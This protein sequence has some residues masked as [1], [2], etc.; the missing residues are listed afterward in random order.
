MSTR[1]NII[2]RTV[3]RI[4]IPVQRQ[5]VCDIPQIRILLE[6][7]SLICIIIPRPQILKSGIR[8]IALCIIPIEVCMLCTSQRHLAVWV[9]LVYACHHTVIPGIG[10]HAA[11]SVIQIVAGF[12]TYQVTRFRPDIISRQPLS[13]IIAVA[14]CCFAIVCFLTLSYAIKQVVLSNRFFI[15]S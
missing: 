6:E 11:S 2:Q 10:C 8:I 3:L 15:L 13:S 12:I 1:I 7:S 5:R 9:M 14:S 4:S